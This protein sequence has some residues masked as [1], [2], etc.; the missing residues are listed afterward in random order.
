[1]SVLNQVLGSSSRSGKKRLVILQCFSTSLNL[2]VHFHCVTDSGWGELF[3]HC[4]RL[5]KSTFSIC[6]EL[7]RQHW[8]SKLLDTLLGKSHAG[9]PGEGKTT[10]QRPSLESTSGWG[11]PLG[12]EPDSVF[13]YVRYQPWLCPLIYCRS[14]ALPIKEGDDFVRTSKHG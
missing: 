14:F 3:L 1:M 10:S 4:S 2:S 11:A 7:W 12:G 9:L 13:Q 5:C 6:C 8:D